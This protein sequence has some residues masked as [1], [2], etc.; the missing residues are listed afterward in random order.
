ML[1]V[2]AASADTPRQARRD[3]PNETRT[4]G[5]LC[6]PPFKRAHVGDAIVRLDEVLRDLQKNRRGN[7]AGASTLFGNGRF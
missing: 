7:Y 1:T 2:A 3:G 6:M 4:A 5:G